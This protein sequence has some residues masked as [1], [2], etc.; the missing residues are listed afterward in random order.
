MTQPLPSEASTGRGACVCA[1]ATHLPWKAGGRDFQEG[2]FGKG[3]TGYWT[4]LEKGESYPDN[5]CR[6]KMEKKNSRQRFS[7]CKSKEGVRSLQEV[8][9]YKKIKFG[10]A[11][12]A[13]RWEGAEEGLDFV[14]S[15]QMAGSLGGCCGGER[16]TVE[17]SL[18]E[19]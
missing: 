3:D 15:L 7:S 19:C 8:Q 16:S 13:G 14:R 17:H 11:H 5:Q 6:H 10:E 4:C 2:L 9:F 18:A 1:H 12:G